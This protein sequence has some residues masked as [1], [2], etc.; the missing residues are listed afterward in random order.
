M[1]FL[2]QVTHILQQVEGE[3][4]LKVPDV[5][6]GEDPAIMA[7]DKAVVAQLVSAVEEWSRVISAVVDDQLKKTPSGEG[8]LAEVDF[9]RERNSV[10]S[11]FYEQL[12]TVQVQKILVVLKAANSPSNFEYHHMELNNYYMEAK[13]NVKFLGTLERHFK[14][15]SQGA[16]FSIVLDTLPNMMNSLRMVWVISRHYNTDDRMAPLMERIAWE[17]CRRATTVVNHRTIFK[18]VQLVCSRLIHACV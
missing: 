6:L 2:V 7:Q 10:L 9:W 17:L 16:N 1:C 4:K 5:D 11:M 14:N 15:L 12:K 13:D 8:P 18:L 3:I